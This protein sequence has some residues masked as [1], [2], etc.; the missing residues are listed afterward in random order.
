VEKRINADVDHG[1]DTTV[2]VNAIYKAV[3]SNKPKLR[4]LAASSF[5]KLAVKLHFILP[6]SIFE[7]MM[8]NSAGIP[9]K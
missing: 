5:Q 2:I 1:S 4:Y 7:K 8:M 3:K 9:K 6:S